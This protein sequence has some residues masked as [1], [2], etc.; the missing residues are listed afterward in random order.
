ME[1]LGELA[2]GV[3]H[4]FNN[5]L[6][7]IL[8]YTSFVAE[9]TQGDDSVQAD[10]EQI[11]TAAKRAADL[12]R[13]LLIFGRRETVR[14]EVIDLNSIVVDMHALLSRSIGEHVELVVHTDPRPMSVNAD[15]GQIEQVL[16]S[17]AVNARDAMHDGGTLTIETAMTDLDDDYCRLHPEVQPGTF[18]EISVSDTGVGMS[19]DVRPHIFEPFFTTKPKG[20][21]PA[22]GWPRCTG[23]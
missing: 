13:Q 21:G 6:A 1:S 14:P 5:L 23:S 10:L 12:T 20:E 2:G 18:V 19:A 22:S 11:K 4:D 8:N 3:A 7:V 16:V 9:Q 15:Q 17:L